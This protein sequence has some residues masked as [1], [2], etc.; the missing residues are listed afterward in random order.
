MDVDDVG[1]GI[2]AVIPDRLGQ[3]RPGDDMA[4][5]P[6]QVGKQLELLVEKLDLPP[7]AGRGAA[8][9]VEAQA[10]DLQP[11]SS[12]APGSRAAHDRLQP[13]DQLVKGEGLGQI[14]VR[15][16]PEALDPVVH[17]A[18][19][20]QE[21]DRSPFPLGAKGAEH[22][23]SVQPGQVPVEDDRIVPPVKGRA[24]ALYPVGRVLAHMP[25]LGQAAANIVRG[26]RIILYEKKLQRQPSF[27]RRASSMDSRATAGFPIS[28]DCRRPLEASGRS[29]ARSSGR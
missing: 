9:Q 20:R 12:L 24:Q 10:S 18:Q 15:S 8:E 26:L 19:R 16:R 13:G 22:R 23:Q 28:R 7:V 25:E 11:G 17:L 2:E 14:I 21:K 27:T 1:A 29:C 3:H 6:H 4:G 5:V